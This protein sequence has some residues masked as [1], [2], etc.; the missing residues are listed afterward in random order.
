MQLDLL[1]HAQAVIEQV[2]QAVAAARPGLD[3]EHDPIAAAL[4]AEGYLARLEMTLQRHQPERARSDLEHAH[5]PIPGSRHADHVLVA[6]AH[7]T[8]VPLR[9]LE[10]RELCRRPAVGVLLQARHQALRRDLRVADPGSVETVEERARP[11]AHSLCVLIHQAVRQGRRRV[12]VPGARFLRSSY[13]RGPPH[14]APRCER[15]ANGPASGRRD[16]T[17]ERNPAGAET[18]HCLRAGHARPLPA[19]GTVHARRM[20]G[21]AVPHAHERAQQAGVA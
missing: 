12:F 8:L 3:L 15:H 14:V 10:G 13:R 21:V 1:R 6:R 4:D 9:F 18:G 17:S 20:S 2:G 7:A 5:G 16:R 11:V 19:H